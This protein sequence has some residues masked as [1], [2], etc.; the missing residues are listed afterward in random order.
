MGKETVNITQ[1]PTPC[2]K[3]I[4]ELMI[5][6]NGIWKWTARILAIC[7]IALFS[8]LGS[9]V[10]SKQQE[11]EQTNTQQEISIKV[12]QAYIVSTDKAILEI[13]DSM[14]QEAVRD[15]KIDSI[16]QD[17]ALKVNIMFDSR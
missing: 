7:L 2:G 14:I 8:W 9:Q 5:N 13:R 6:K 3:K 10:W 12:L 15:K 4:G 1:P 16:I 11:I 17:L